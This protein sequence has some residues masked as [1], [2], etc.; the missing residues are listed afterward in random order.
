MSVF[1][2]FGKSIPKIFEVNIHD[3][4]KSSHYEKMKGKYISVPVAIDEPKFI[5][6]VGDIEL[7]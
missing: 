6:L 7:Q 2:S 1:N 4:S 5:N 3:V